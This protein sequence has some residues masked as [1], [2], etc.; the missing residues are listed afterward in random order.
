VRLFAAHTDDDALVK[1][2]ETLVAHRNN[3]AH[4]AFVRGFL[5]AGDDQGMAV[6]VATIHAQAREA[7]ALV[8]EI[9]DRALKLPVTPD[10]W[11]AHRAS[12]VEQP[13]E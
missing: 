2:L 3:A 11:A 4:R 9:L 12:E 13:A 10:Q 8:E 5:R 6:D 7:L 1:R